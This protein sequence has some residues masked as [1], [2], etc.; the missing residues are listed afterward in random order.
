[1]SFIVYADDGH[2]CDDNIVSSSKRC[3]VYCM[4]EGREW[5]R[6]P[7]ASSSSRRRPIRREAANSVPRVWCCAPRVWCCAPRYMCRRR[8]RRR[9]RRRARGING[10]YS[11]VAVTTSSVTVW[12]WCR[13][14]CVYCCIRIVRAVTGVACGG[15]RLWKGVRG[16]VWWWC[17]SARLCVVSAIVVRR[18]SGRVVATAVAD[19][20]ARR[21]EL[22]ALPMYIPLRLY[23]RRP[24]HTPYTYI[25][26]YVYT[27]I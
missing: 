4:R 1:M 12:R 22:S 11:A 18:R 16:R 3:R 13:R 25:I 15:L 26:F 17:I 8:R 2:A 19:T 27:Y 20:N 21:P 10:M 5:V 9:R 14:R 6:P 7:R 24:A 23:P